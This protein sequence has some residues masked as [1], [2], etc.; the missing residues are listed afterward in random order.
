MK[1]TIEVSDDLFARAR[2]L[3]ERD[4]G[5]MRALV[6]EGLRLALQ[7]REH[8]RRPAQFKIKTFAGK[9]AKAG[10]SAE[11]EGAGWESVRSAIY[12]QP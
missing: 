8:P 12:G 7:A 4:G 6:E 11:F 2:A 10:L 3:A 9:G 5:T 1:T